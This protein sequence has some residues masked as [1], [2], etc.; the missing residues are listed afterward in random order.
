[1]RACA[2]TIVK[3]LASRLVYREGLTFVESMPDLRL[4]MFA[5][6]YLEQEQRVEALAAEVAASGHP[7]AD[8]VEALLLQSGVRVAAEEQMLKPGELP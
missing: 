4:P 2:Q 8:N 3:S 6:S 7:F 5:L 1:M